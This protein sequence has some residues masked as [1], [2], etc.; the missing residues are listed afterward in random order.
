MIMLISEAI[1]YSEELMRSSYFM[2][3]IHGKEAMEY[4]TFQ[5]SKGEKWVIIPDYEIEIPAERLEILYS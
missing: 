4:F 3:R 1:K 5:Q 2:N